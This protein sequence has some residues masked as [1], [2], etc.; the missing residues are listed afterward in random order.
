ML[1]LTSYLVKELKEELKKKKKPEHKCNLLPE[2]LSAQAD[3]VGDMT[4]GAFGTELELEMVNCNAVPL[5]TGNSLLWAA[6]AQAPQ[7]G[8]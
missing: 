5:V 1:I 2:S 3:C 4:R 7:F 8:P 6:I